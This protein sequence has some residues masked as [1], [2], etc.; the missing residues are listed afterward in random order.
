MTDEELRL[1]CLRLAHCERAESNEVVERARMYADFVTGKNDADVASG[2]VTPD[3][4]SQPGAP[5]VLS[6]WLM[7][8]CRMST[9]F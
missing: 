8:C 4:A 6:G 5:A 2:A 7:P 1:E 3:R 9:A